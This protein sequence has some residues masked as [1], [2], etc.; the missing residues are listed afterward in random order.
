MNRAYEVKV[1][2]GEN[3]QAYSFVVIASTDEQA[4]R[5]AKT[6]ARKASGVKSGWRCIGLR[7]RVAQL[8][9]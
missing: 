8:V 2:R 6:R 5:K 1:Q 4:V 9:V 3:V 7:E